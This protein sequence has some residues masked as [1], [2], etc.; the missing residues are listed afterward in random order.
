MS[1]HFTLLPLNS[2]RF[3]AVSFSLDATRPDE[4]YARLELSLA[5]LDVEGEV[6]LDLL[7]CNGKGGRRFFAVRFDGARLLLNTL[8]PE[9]PESLEKDVRSLCASFYQKNTRK[10]ERSIL[11]PAARAA[12]AHAA[13]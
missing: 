13:A 9:K 4:Y 7:A 3:R 6:L 8:R 2:A 1:K 5:K 12:I 11:S 10:M